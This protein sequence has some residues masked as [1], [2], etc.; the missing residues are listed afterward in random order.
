MDGGVRN[1][2]K[3]K[4]ILFGAGFYGRMAYYKLRDRYEIV[5]IIDNN[6]ES[7]S[8]IM[9]DGEEIPITQA[10][11]LLKYDLN[12]VDLII[13]M[14]HYTDVVY[15]LFRSGIDRYY[16]F[17]GGFIYYSDKSIV[18]KPFE[19]LDCAP[20]VKKPNN[21][22][23]IL[24]VQETACIRTHKIATVMK[25]MGYSVY[26]LYQQNPPIDG[27]SGFYKVYDKIWS[28]TSIDGMISFISNSEFDIIHC[29]NEPDLLVNIAKLTSKPIVADTH[30]LL[31]IQGTRSVSEMYL[32]YCAN[33]NC[34][35]NIYPSRGVME[36]A[37][38]KYNN[39]NRLG[40]VLENY[41]LDEIYT[42]PDAEKLSDRDGELH[43]VY[44]GGIS[45]DKLDPKYFEDMWLMIANAGVH[46][47]FYSSNVEY[48]KKIELKS[49]YLH[50][51][52]NVGSDRIIEEMQKYDCG[53]MLYNIADPRRRV[54]LETCSPNKMYEYLNSK[55][56]L[57]GNVKAHIGFMKEYKVGGGIAFD[58][59]I[60]QQILE[61]S[62]IKIPNNFLTDNKLTMRARAV[63]IEDFYKKVIKRKKK[64]KT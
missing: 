25:E 50:Y 11:E 44:E 3:H 19:A 10:N 37:E 53:L 58:K 42:Q 41:I 9:V 59:D 32:E 56:P 49:D 7:I 47:H 64:D 46:V 6:A 34:D 35:G 5:C 22:K 57:I 1:S 54:D 52:G 14:Y 33:M 61:I 23:N 36:I 16:V 40:Y 13:C 45:E 28:F 18:M 4:I 21:E 63:E 20:Y 12:N 51:E 15:Q 39:P 62:H 48:C 55:I 60:K 8:S 38:Q 2:M 24:F 30:D 43:C 27:Y 26:L 31:S 17:L 29:S